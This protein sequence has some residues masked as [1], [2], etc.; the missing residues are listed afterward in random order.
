M[1]HDKLLSDTLVNFTTN[2]TNRNLKEQKE[3]KN[4]D[5]GKREVKKMLAKINQKYLKKS[6]TFIFK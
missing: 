5:H 2:K 3:R 6:Q 4:M 1:L